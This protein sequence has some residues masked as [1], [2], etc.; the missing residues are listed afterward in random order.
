MSHSCSLVNQ[1]KYN[2]WNGIKKCNSQSVGVTSK[3]FL[4]YN[5]PAA[6]KMAS[7]LSKYSLS[8]TITP[9]TMASG[10]SASEKFGA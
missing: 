3:N 9:S 6:L 8:T 1:I 5:K 2:F 10:L 4:I 7:C